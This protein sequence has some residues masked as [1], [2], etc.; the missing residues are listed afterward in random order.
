MSYS[1]SKEQLDNI[2]KDIGKELKK[3]LKNKK[4]FL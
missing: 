3:K 1:F 2:F 4:L